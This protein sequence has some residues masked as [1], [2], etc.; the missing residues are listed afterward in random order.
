MTTE[1]AAASVIIENGII[2][3]NTDD[4]TLNTH[5]VR[6]RVYIDTYVIATEPLIVDVEF[7]SPP[8]KFDRIGFSV[9]AITCSPADV[10]WS[11]E[12]PPVVSPE[13]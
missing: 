10:T 13:I 12:L 5:T 8:P 7:V 11:L 2:T 3:V 1:Q 9:I 4:Y 6:L